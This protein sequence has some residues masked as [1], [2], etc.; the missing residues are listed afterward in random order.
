MISFLVRGADESS[1]PTETND[2]YAYLALSWK[3][4][5][6]YLHQYPSDLDFLLNSR[7]LTSH[8]SEQSL[9]AFCSCMFIHLG[10]FSSRVCSTLCI[11]GLGTP[12]Q[13]NSRPLDLLES[14]MVDGG[15]NGTSLI[16]LKYNE[17]I[18]SETYIYIYIYIYIYKYLNISI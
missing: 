8:L 15:F 9:R 7:Q 12:C 4:S 3:T 18:V 10:L 11:V 1:I 14:Q 6:Y 2:G 13:M 5:L 16:N 17:V